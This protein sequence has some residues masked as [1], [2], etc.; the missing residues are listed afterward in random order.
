MREGSDMW[1][2]HD[3]TM[4]SMVNML[5]SHGAVQDLFELG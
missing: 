3:G 2:P 4:S 1:A 5:C